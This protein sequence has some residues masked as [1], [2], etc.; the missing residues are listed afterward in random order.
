MAA[1]SG[2]NANHKPSLT[3]I[4]LMTRYSIHSIRSPSIVTS[5]DG[6]ESEFHHSKWKLVYLRVP[7]STLDH[8]TMPQSS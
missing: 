3:G 2:Q 4:E 8:L 6:V 1:K 5:G 7:N